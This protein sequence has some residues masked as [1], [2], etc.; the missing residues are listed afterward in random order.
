MRTAIIHDT[1]NDGTMAAA[2]IL[3]AEP[4][5]ALFPVR[6]YEKERLA[7]LST[8]LPN[9]YDNVCMVDISAPGETMVKFS[10]A[11]KF[12][13]FDHHTSA[14]GAFGMYD[15]RQAIGKSATALVWEYVNPRLQMPP[16]AAYINEYDIFHEQNEPRF[17][18]LVI[19]FQIF[20][21][22][23]CNV[24]AYLEISRQLDKRPQLLDGFVDIGRKLWASELALYNHAPITAREIGPY[25]VLVGTK[26]ASPGRYAWWLRK[27]EYKSDFFISGRDAGD[28]WVYS[29]RSL[30]PGADCLEF[31]DR[32]GFA[33]GGHVKAAG[34][35]TPTQL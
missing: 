15:G 18:N 31:I 32:M 33:G 25:K 7:E 21:E 29:I 3:N 27:L 19:P 12:L 22:R 30:R 11:Q 13:W 28:K 8:I 35:S 5:A 10:I 2:L 14:E 20:M 26:P 4:E 1:D 6:S 16:W 17:A 9:L 24:Q 34:F 23:V